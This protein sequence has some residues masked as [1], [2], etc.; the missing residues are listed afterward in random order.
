MLGD[1]G[2]GKIM[3]FVFVVDRLVKVYMVCVYYCK[4]DGEI[5]QFVN[6]YWSFLWQFFKG[7]FSLKFVFRQWYK[8]RE[9]VLIDLM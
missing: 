2:S 5:N 8:E 6:I 1:M 3:M 4:D 9:S 7:W